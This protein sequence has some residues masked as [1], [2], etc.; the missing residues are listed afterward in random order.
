M[1]KQM[2]EGA[3][4]SIELDKNKIDEAIASSGKY[5]EDG[6]FIKKWE[7]GESESDTQNR[8]IT[9]ISKN[10]SKYIGTLDQKFKRDG[11]GLQIFENG[12]KYFGQFTQDQ[13][14]EDGIYFWFPVSNETNTQS[15]LFLG[16]W[17]ENKKNN[18]GMYLWID[19]PLNNTEYEN[20]DI[21]VYIGE[22][23]NEKY[24]RGTYLCKKNNNLSLYHGNFDKD[25]KKTDDNAFFYTSQ[26][27]R[28]YFGKINK[29][30]L[31][32]GYLGSVDDGDEVKD[33][34]FCN[35][36]DDGSVKEI[37]EASK[38]NQDEAEDTKKKIIGL[39]KG[40]LS[41]GGF[42]KKIYG[43][44]LK[45]KNKVDNLFCDVAIFDKKDYFPDLQKLLNK[46]KRKNIYTYIEEN[47]FGREF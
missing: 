33:F 10:N 12:D 44:Y 6:I 5:E 36:N 25:G 35:F 14:D 19:E 29:D 31:L 9:E 34:V 17:K 42:F 47:F 28:I 26:T 18:N 16:N 27:N 13:R 37:L 1:D 15:E 38:L 32:S 11:Y 23:E 45:V 4:N 22:L 41:D 24:I 8:Y 39:Y 43:K 2:K 7:G 40:V 20:A 21:D 46:Y 30:I 3:T